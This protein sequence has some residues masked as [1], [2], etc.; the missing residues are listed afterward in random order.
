[1]RVLH[2]VE[3]LASGVLSSLQILSAE[4][5]KLG[6]E[7]TILY[8][9]GPDTPSAHELDRSFPVVHRRVE[10]KGYRRL[11]APLVL[12]KGLLQQDLDEYDVIH[13]HSSWAGVIVRAT[14]CDRTRWSRIWYSPHAYGFLRTDTHPVVRHSAVL[15]ER[16]LSRVGSVAAV[17]ESEAELAREVTGAR[18]VTVLHNR[19][20]I[21]A[22][23]RLTNTAATR[24]PLVV[25]AGRLA[26]QKDP[27]R[28]ARIAERLQR[29]AE[30]VW[31]GAG[32]EG[33]RVFAN[34]PVTALRWTS[35]DQTLRHLASANIYLSTSRW[36]GLPLALVEAQA[37]GLP[38][39]GTD[40]PGNRDVIQHE[41]TGYLSD[42]DDAMETACRSLLADPSR[43]NEMSDAARL[44]ARK[45]FD[46][47]ALGAEALAMY[48]QAVQ[49]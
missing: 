44:S 14:A 10:L 45:R 29:Q 6:A 35:R 27:E 41:Q 42:G 46:V 43:W 12:A 34:S 48:C 28:F 32:A 11:A 2:V 5:A 31:I 4:Q 24:K 20:D 47:G 15:A 17:S 30:F 16:L 13:A 37:M 23:P 1:M 39:V 38:A 36:E 26:P 33:E 40:V 3:E 9:R 49:L 25:T 21:A 22:L 18:R 7:V 8:T 19:V